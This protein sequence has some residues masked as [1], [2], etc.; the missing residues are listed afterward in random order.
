MSRTRA[1]ERSRIRGVLLVANSVGAVASAVLAA[2]GVARPAY[3][4]PGTP[5]SPLT[6]FWAAA[7]AARTWAITGPLLVGMARR[8]RPS[9]QLL[10]AAG[11]VQLLDS[12]LGVQRRDPR[13]ALLPAVMGVVHLV[14]ARVLTATET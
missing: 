12:A 3:V 14:S 11:T 13:M 1:S 6:Q 5:S 9:R 7:S 4:A 10:V 8:G 2:V